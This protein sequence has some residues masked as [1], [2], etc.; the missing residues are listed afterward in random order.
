MLT[1][2]TTTIL[3][4]ILL[5]AFN[6]LR[7]LG[8][9]M[10]TPTIVLI[11][12]FMAIPVILSFFPCTGYHYKPVICKGSENM[13]C[14]AITFDDGPDPDHTPALLDILAQY[15]VQATFF[16]IGRK[17]PGNEEIVRRM[18][19]DGHQIGNHS[20]TH[21]WFWSFLPP[22]RMAAEMEK[23]NQLIHS[24]TDQAPR[25]FRPPYG[26]INPM[27]SIALKMF[28]LQ[29]VAWNRRSFDTST[30]DPAQIL[31]KFSRSLKAGDILLF[32]DTSPGTLS[33]MGKLLEQIERKGLQPVVLNTLLHEPVHL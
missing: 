9:S 20:Y 12:L 26:V 28:P 33:M 14:I 2:R 25:W 1:F 29:V 17:I 19:R 27:V 15:R 23:T 7:G 18:I 16:L 10:F 24:L 5:L 30:K 21:G 31:R 22:Q 8:Y 13:P 3:F 6:L 11:S 4:F 32:H